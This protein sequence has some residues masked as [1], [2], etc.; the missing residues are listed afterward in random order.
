M[1]TA[2]HTPGPWY[3]DKV[4][5]GHCRHVVVDSEGFTIANPSPMGEADARLIAAAPDLLAALQRLVHPSA[6]DTDLSHALDVIARAA[7]GAI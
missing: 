5:T 7:G 1:E 6:D 2:T 3:W 4:S